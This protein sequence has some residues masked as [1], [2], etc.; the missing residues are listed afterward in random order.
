MLQQDRLRFLDVDTKPSEAQLE[1]LVNE[2]SRALAA[3][4]NEKGASLNAFLALI[5]KFRAVESVA[6]FHQRYHR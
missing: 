6:Q 4:R 5:L 3:K 1:Q 2:L